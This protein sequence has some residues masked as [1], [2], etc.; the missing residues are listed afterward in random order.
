MG[1]EQAAWFE[2]SRMWTSVLWRG[3]S[4]NVTCPHLG[5]VGSRAGPG[6]SSEPPRATSGLFCPR[7]HRTYK[8]SSLSFQNQDPFG[9]GA[10]E[11]PFLWEFVF[12][13]REGTIHRWMLLV[14]STSCG[15]QQS[16]SLLS[17]PTSQ[18]STGAVMSQMCLHSNEPASTEVR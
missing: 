2:G 12:R 16:K 1:K 5:T 4:A 6:S 10:L 9:V 11:S 8:H 18:S 3:S 14:S 15:R 17:V 7:H 13:A